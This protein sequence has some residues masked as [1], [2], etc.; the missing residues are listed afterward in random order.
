MGGMGSGQWRSRGACRVDR[1]SSI[2]INDLRQRRL[3]SAGELRYHSHNEQDAGQSVVERI[4]LDYTRTKLWRAARLVPLPRLRTQMRQ[5]RQQPMRLP[6][7]VRKRER[8]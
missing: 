8:L 5:A 7:A 4:Q 6:W 2:S 1:L 3:L